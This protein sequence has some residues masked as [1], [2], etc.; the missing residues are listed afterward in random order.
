MRREHSKTVCARDA[1]TNEA[2]G[3]SSSSLEARVKPIA[4]FCLIAILSSAPE[5]ALP[6][7]SE[8]AAGTIPDDIASWLETY[9]ASRETFNGGVVHYPQSVQFVEG[10]LGDQPAGLVLFS[11][12]G[13]RG[14][15]DYLSYLAL[16]FKRQGKFVFCCLRRA[17]GKGTRSVDD[18]NFKDP[19]IRISGK[20]FVPGK[21]AMCCPSK[22][23]S[24]DLVVASG[25]LVE[26]RRASNNRSRGP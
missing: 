17:G 14:G 26:K 4:L 1:H 7:T 24:M 18:F 3:R 23:Y 5:A 10:D 19:G 12:E 11:L 22:P 16:F 6:N 8:P 25:Q 21:D 20:E 13:I 15:T 2:A 9:V